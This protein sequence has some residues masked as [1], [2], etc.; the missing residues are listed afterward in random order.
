M[1]GSCPLCSAKIYLLLTRWE[2]NKRRKSAN[3]PKYTVTHAEI[4]IRQSGKLFLVGKFECGQCGIAGGLWTNIT[5]KPVKTHTH[6]QIIQINKIF[7][8]RASKLWLKLN[9]M[10]RWNSLVLFPPTSSSN[11]FADVLYFILC[12]PLW[13]LCAVLN[14]KERIF[15]GFLCKIFTS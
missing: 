9:K 2:E 10:V 15:N 11:H 13:M 6:I 4:Q 8:T 3:K 7:V 5:R 1:G 14:N 12:L